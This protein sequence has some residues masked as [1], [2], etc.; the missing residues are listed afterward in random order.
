MF[1]L[2]IC[3]AVLYFIVHDYIVYYGWITVDCQVMSLPVRNSSH[4][5]FGHDVCK[6]HVEVLQY[7]IA[8][9]MWY[10]NFSDFFTNC[11][12]YS[13]TQIVLLSVKA[14]LPFHSMCQWP[15]IVGPRSCKLVTSLAWL[16]V[17]TGKFRLVANFPQCSG[18]S[19]WGYSCSFIKWDLSTAM[20]CCPEWWN[21]NSLRLAHQTS[22]VFQIFWVPWQ[23]KYLSA[24]HICEFV[25]VLYG[26]PWNV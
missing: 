24:C 2:Y 1:V 10:T 5:V 16:P 11:V 18:V 14:P 21:M 25:W 17:A 20:C 3:E 12:Q 13:W 4:L 22:P 26:H 19:F 9:A 7:G 15:V 8:C 23:P 6:Q